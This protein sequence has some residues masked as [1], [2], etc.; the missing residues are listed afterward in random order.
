MEGLHI[1]VLFMASPDGTRPNMA[2]TDM[3]FSVLVAHLVV[4]DIFYVPIGNP[5]MSDDG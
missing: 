1:K 4:A 3:C 2:S 5:G